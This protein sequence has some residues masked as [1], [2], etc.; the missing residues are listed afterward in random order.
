MKVRCPIQVGSYRRDTADI[1]EAIKSC[2]L[3][4][5]NHAGILRVEIVSFNALYR[6]VS[7]FED[8][9]VFDVELSPIEIVEP[10]KNYEI[11]LNELCHQWD[12]IDKVL[13][14]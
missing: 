3:V 7:K 13:R 1:K 8:D 4:I 9:L 12:A 11:I 14:Y 10:L 6:C 5:L 2:V